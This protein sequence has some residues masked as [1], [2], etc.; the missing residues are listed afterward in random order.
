M[1]SFMISFQN[2]IYK[3][4]LNFVHIITHDLFYNLNEVIKFIVAWTTTTIDEL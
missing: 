3:F 2:I 4:K 1:H